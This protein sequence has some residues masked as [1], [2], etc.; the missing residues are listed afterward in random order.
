MQTTKHNLSAGLAELDF[1]ALVKT[2][3]VA[4]GKCMKD[5]NYSLNELHRDQEENDWNSLYLNV[6]YLKD[7]ANR[8]AIVG[9]TLATLKSAIK[10]EEIKIINK[11]AK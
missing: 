6:N 9:E 2:A 5:I 10:R 1:E 3:E 4:H 7:D 8:L 11:R